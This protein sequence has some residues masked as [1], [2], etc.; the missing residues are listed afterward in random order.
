MPAGRGRGGG[1]PRRA[2]GRLGR[3]RG[4]PSRRAGDRHDDPAAGPRIP[5]H[6]RGDPVSTALAGLPDLDPDAGGGIVARRAVIRWGWRLFRREWRQ[7]LLVLGLLTVAVAATIWGASVVTNAQLPPGYPTFGTGAAQVTLPGSDP[8]LAAD[9][10]TIAGR[11]GSAD[12]V[13]KQ[14]ITTGTGQPVQLRAESPHGHY[15]SPML[16]LVSGTYPAGPTWQVTGIVQDPSNLADEFALV[17]PGQV[18]HPSQVVMLLGPAAAQ[19]IGGGTVPGVPAANVLLPTE[20]VSGVSPT[21]LILVVEVLGLAFIGLVSVASFSVMAQRRLRALGM[22]S[23]IGATER[24]VRL[25]MIAGGLVVGATAALAGAVL[26]LAAWFAYAP[27]LQRDTGH[28]VDAAH[29]PWWAFAIGMLFAIATSSLASRRPAKTMAAVPVVAALSGRPAPPTA[30]HRSA[31]PGLIV[32]AAGLACLA[33]SGGLNGVADGNGG[34][35]HA[36]FLLV[37]LVITIVGVCL[38]AP[39]AISVLAAGAGPRL[40]VAIRIALRDLVRYRA[41]SG[42]ALAATTFAVFL[43]MGICIAASIRFDNPLNWIGPNLS[44][45]QVTVPAD[46]SPSPGQSMPLS[47][48]QLVTLTTRV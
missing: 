36:L 41:R 8:Q 2:A 29:L 16:S 14:N 28:V 7:Q 42:A 34:Q 10:A 26:G 30:V 40:P 20:Q 35:G 17:V 38:L 37:G 24:N 31:L 46:Q 23:A 13:E 43:A 5:P 12:L 15:S 45:S 25:V 9:I 4:I 27:T 19:E 32:F 44:S 6:A 21:V 47:G 39:L 33:L 18:T 11:W 48:A 1:D 3:P 22:L